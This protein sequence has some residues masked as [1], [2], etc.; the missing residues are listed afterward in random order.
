MPKIPDAYAP[1]AVLESL[2]AKAR[3]DKIRRQT[4]TY[5]ATATMGNIDYDLAV[6]VHA[7]HDRLIRNKEQPKSG[8]AEGGDREER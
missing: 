2:K 6:A 7:W 5:L 4:L 3:Q 8:R 1:G